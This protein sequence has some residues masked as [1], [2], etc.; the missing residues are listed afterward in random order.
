MQK[1]DTCKYWY[2]TGADSEPNECRRKAPRAATR[3]NLANWPMTKHSMSCG[4][5][6][7]LVGVSAR[8]DWILL[9]VSSA[10]FIGMAAI[11]LGGF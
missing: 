2:L 6:R 11:R 4:E 3:S 1:C 7:R 8:A 10:V 5:G 9:A